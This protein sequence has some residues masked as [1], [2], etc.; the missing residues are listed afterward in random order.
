M[1]GLEFL[2]SNI[3]DLDKLRAI[4][5]KRHRG[6]PKMNAPPKYPDELIITFDY[7][8]KGQMYRSFTIHAEGGP[9]T[10]NSMSES[11]K[12]FVI[13]SC[14][15]LVAD[16]SMDNPALICELED[17]LRYCFNIDNE[18]DT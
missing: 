10:P 1:C 8:D 13:E 17:W 2:V 15:R 6:R 9:Y 16:L 7:L 5:L 14:M 12:R 11:Y 3:I 4:K 18:G